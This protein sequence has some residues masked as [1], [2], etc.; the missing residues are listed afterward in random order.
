MVILN[1]CGFTPCHIL[2]SF[3]PSHSFEQVQFSYPL[4]FSAPPPVPIDLPQCQNLDPKPLT[5][6][7]TFSQKHGLYC[8]TSQNVNR[9]GGPKNGPWGENTE[10]TGAQK[11]QNV[12]RGKTALIK[13]HLWRSGK[14]LSC[15][16]W[17][18]LHPNQRGGSGVSALSQK[19]AV[20]WVPEI[21]Q[22]CVPCSLFACHDDLDAQS[23]SSGRC[24][25]VVKSLHSASCYHHN[26]IHH[27][28]LSDAW[29]LITHVFPFFQTNVLKR[30]ANWNSKWFP[31]AD[32]TQHKGRVV[33]MHACHW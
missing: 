24:C 1:K 23:A 20:P 17:I 10:K 30:V 9:E 15:F 8:L 28:L 12:T 6:N 33:K 25:M 3:G 5:P 21:F 18:K 27:A 26:K 29:G 22:V 32:T 16:G 14:G 11:T 7:P 13:T 31:L 4:S 19:D 2:A